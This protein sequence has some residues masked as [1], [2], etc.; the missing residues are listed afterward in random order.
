VQAGA[1]VPAFFFEP[2]VEAER[3]VGK[4]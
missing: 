1:L 4:A 2:A 3:S